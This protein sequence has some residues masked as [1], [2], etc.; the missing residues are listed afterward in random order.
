MNENQ[1]W[2]IMQGSRIWVDFDIPTRGVARIRPI[3]TTITP[4]R[5]RRGCD[6]MRIV[7]DG[8]R[9]IKDKPP[10]PF[11]EDGSDNKDYAWFSAMAFCLRTNRYHRD[12]D[13]GGDG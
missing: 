13:E 5:R 4:D 7:D 10:H 9:S 1:Q 12:R 2:P 6:W 3:I 11:N 8:D